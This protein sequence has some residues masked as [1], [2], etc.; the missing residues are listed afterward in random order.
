MQGTEMT[1]L[2]IYLPK[3]FHKFKHQTKSL[4]LWR[5]RSVQYIPKKSLNIFHS[6][7]LL[8]GLGK[9]QFWAAFLLR[10]LQ[11]QHLS[12]T[13]EGN[14]LKKELAVV[15]VYFHEW[16]IDA[17]RRWQGLSVLQQHQGAQ[18]AQL[19]QLRRQTCLGHFIMKY[20]CPCRVLVISPTCW[21]L[22]PSGLR[23][24]SCKAPWLWVTSFCSS[25]QQ[26]RWSPRGE[27]LKSWRGCSIACL[28]LPSWNSSAANWCSILN[29]PH[30]FDQYVW[31]TWRDQIN[32]YIL[33][34]PERVCLHL[35]LALHHS[36]ER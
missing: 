29:Y 10:R 6:G 24:Y 2:Q 27:K 26:A 14:K 21:W 5:I 22:L 28:M 17:S 8:E 4:D 18:L 1:L 33:D 13:Q 11:Q 32:H 15:K 34:A 20:D 31:W 9:C 3:A 16:Q 19:S 7:R 12:E 25:L 35:N 36:P 23:R 30:I